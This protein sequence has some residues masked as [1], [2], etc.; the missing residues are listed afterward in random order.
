VLHSNGGALYI[1][2]NN[3]LELI[4]MTINS[5]KAHISGG[6]LLIQNSNNISLLY[7]NISQN[8][9]LN[10]N[11]GGIYL[12]DYNIINITFVNIDSN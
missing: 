1:F 10:S 7:S 8:V 12:F 11:G 2:N 5:N 3:Q 9:V 4:Y 6:G